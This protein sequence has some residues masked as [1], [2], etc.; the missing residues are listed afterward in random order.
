MVALHELHFDRMRSLESAILS[1][2]RGA[3]HLRF[4]DN[5]LRPLDF[6][7]DARG[8]TEGGQ[9]AELPPFTRPHFPR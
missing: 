9:L 7:E 8:E 4:S 3:L 5:W 1:N 2:G 6:G